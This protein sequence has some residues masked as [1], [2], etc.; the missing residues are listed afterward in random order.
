MTSR[1]P[2][3]PARSRDEVAGDTDLA[4]GGTQIGTNL[5]FTKFLFIVPQK[6]DD[7]ARVRVR[8]AG[9]QIARGFF[10]DFDA[11]GTR[12][13]QPQETI[14]FLV[15]DSA[16]RAMQ[17]IAAA[18]YA[19]HVS[20]NYRPRL[21]E[22]ETELRRRL[23]EYA[24]I[25]T[26]DGATRPTRYT[27]AEMQAYAY[28]PARLR[29]SGRVAPHAIVIPLSKASDWWEKSALERHTY[30]YPHV[31]QA[32]GCPVKGHAQAADAGI[33]T[34]F[35]RLY[36]N[37]DGY[38]REGE[39]DFVTYFECTTEHLALFDVIC[40][41]LRDPRQNPEWRYVIEGPEW[42]GRRVLRW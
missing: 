3:G 7:A 39:F 21:Q 17:G 26:L 12:D 11:D 24:E 33:A 8:T 2:T 34:V 6:D 27:S 15:A 30:F 36:H 32:S 19:V 1:I 41:A 13:V 38:Q 28:R 20:A 23:G 35:R 5:A 18:R 31:D 25:F 42:R 10:N 37:P 40:R 22:L 9:A 29:E 14:Q 16:N 4:N